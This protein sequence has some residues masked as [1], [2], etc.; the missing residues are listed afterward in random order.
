ML[1]EW[2]L[3]PAITYLNHPTVGATPKRVLEA[4]HA[5]VLEAERQPSRFQ[6]RELTSI[7]VGQWRPEK[8]RLRVAADAVAAFVGA[9]GEDLVFVDNTT[10]GINAVFHSFPLAQGDD[11]LVSE[12]SYG[13]VVNA[14]RFVT[15]QRGASLTTVQMPPV[16]RA[17]AI[18]DAILAAVT[19]RTRLALLEHIIPEAALVLPVAEIAAR[20]KARGVATVVDGAHTPGAIALDVPSIGADYY[21]ANLHKSAFVPRSSGFLWA[22]PERQAGLHPPVIS[23]GLDQG[24]TDEFD[25][26]GTRDASAH[27]AA[28]AALAFIESF[29]LQR[30]LEY[31][32]ALVWKG[33]HL[34]AERWGTTFDTP[35]SMV[36][37]MASVPLP[38]SLGST[39][40]DGARVRDWLLFEHNIEVG[41]NVWRGQLRVRVAAQIY[42]DLDDFERLAAAVAA[43]A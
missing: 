2:Y 29:G 34:L 8:P 42:N 30:I 35:E 14:A 9:R 7:I 38:A 32:H 1:S 4:Q 20:L 33:S 43:R 36:G 39:R 40:E 10:S 3:D 15:R 12:L 13:G 18:A 31:N 28:P 25:L 37:T 21:V 19:P 22:A 16:L 27:L 41:I 17:D 5:I 24:F 23:W 11:L 6:L 26:A